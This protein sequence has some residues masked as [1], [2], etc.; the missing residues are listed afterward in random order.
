MLHLKH[1]H[2]LDFPHLTFTP[3]YGMQL[4]PV[5]VDDDE[6][7]RAIADDT[8]LRDNNWELSER[9]D[10]VQLDEFWNEVQQDVR[11]DP[12]WFSVTGAE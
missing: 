4:S 12:E 1:K 9:P 2:H 8:V 5:P 6:L 7:S 3:H 11:Q 10:A